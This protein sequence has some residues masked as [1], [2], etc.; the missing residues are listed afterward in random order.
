MNK[1]VTLQSVGSYD[2]LAKLGHGGMGNVYKAQHRT[3]G[4]FVAVKVASRR[5]AQHPTLKRRF[6]T[7]F[8]VAN[9]VSH[10]NLVRSLDEGE[11]EGTPYLVMELVEGQSL[12]QRLKNLEPLPEPEARS[13]FTQVAKALQ[14]LHEKM[15]VHRDIK[16]G[17]ILLGE[18]GITKLAD[19]GLGKFLDS[20]SIL[21]HSRVGLGTL[22]Y[23][24]PEQ[25]DDAKHVDQRCDLY[26]LAATLYVALTTKYPFGTGSMYQMIQKKRANQFTPLSRVLPSVS[27]A[28]DKL[29]ERSLNADP[30]VR[31]ASCAEVLAVLQRAAEDR[32]TLPGKVPPPGRRP[33]PL[34]SPPSSVLERRASVR[35]ATNLNSKCSMV[36]REEEV[37]EA[38]VLDL[39]ANGLCL[40]V[41][42]RFEPKTTLQVT[43]ILAPDDAHSVY[44]QTRWVRQFEQEMWLVGCVFSEPLS[45]LELE[46][47]L[48]CGAEQTRVDGPQV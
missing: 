40:Q 38:T 43:I 9:Q 42:R 17:N 36:A 22:E 6:H 29:V 41:P 34:P 25:F 26:S 4:E 44:V 14:F 33:P 7:E 16:P 39:S 13:V 21:T 45:A 2:L 35:Y 27:P 28:L 3:T 15:I 46:K 12:A 18:N 11:H 5:V 20:D 10:P 31:P 37:W 19:F 8:L 24:A 1:P 30:D 32:A 23:A 47:L 48:M